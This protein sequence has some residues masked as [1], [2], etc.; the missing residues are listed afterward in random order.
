MDLETEYIELGLQL[1]LTVIAMSLTLLIDFS[2]PITF[3]YGLGIPI[4]FGYTAVI[5][6]KS[7]KKSSFGAVIGLVF[8]PLGVFAALASVFTLVCNV[9]VSLFA[10]GGSF[11]DH[12]SA[13]AIPLLLLGILIGG[14]T[15]V[16]ASYDAEFE[17][18]L[19]NRTVEIG[20]DKTIAMIELTGMD[21]VEETDAIER[22]A[23]ATIFSTQNYVMNDYAQRTGET[24]LQA[25]ESSFENAR[26]DLPS[27]IAEQAETNPEEMRDRTEDMIGNTVSGRIPLAVFVFAVS[28]LYALQ[29]LLGLLTALSAQLFVVLRDFF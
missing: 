28:T 9:F 24:D 7:F 19:E 2:R 12:Y 29:P 4:L 20:A 16:Y 25:L 27:Q 14:G 15:A 1:A 21:Q 8:I 23:N 17:A 22:S 6:E 5:S 3:L 26:N 10:S 11:K 13:T 18:S